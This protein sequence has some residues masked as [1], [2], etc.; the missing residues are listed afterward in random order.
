M[1]WSSLAREFF[2]PT[3]E[4]KTVSIRITAA[5]VATIIAVASSAFDAAKGSRNGGNSYLP[6]QYCVPP[7]DALDAQT[8]YCR[9]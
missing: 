4:D 9:A 6:A 8:I 5:F 3:R 2:L 1:R 7:D